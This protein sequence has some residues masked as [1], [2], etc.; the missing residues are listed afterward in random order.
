MVVEA[1]E[2]QGF[3]ALVGQILPAVLVL[4]SLRSLFHLISIL[5]MLFIEHYSSLTSL[6]GIRKVCECLC[7][8]L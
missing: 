4:P 6:V 8:Q 7:L 3:L 2:L 5:I 1:D